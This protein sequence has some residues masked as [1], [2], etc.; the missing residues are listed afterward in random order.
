[1]KIRLMGSPDLI[2]AWGEELQRAYGVTGRVYP[3]RGGNDVRLYVDL[4]DR[5]AAALVGLDGQT[6][7]APAGKAIRKGGKA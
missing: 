2:R 4:D 6:P 5:Q 1:M 7:P 3:C